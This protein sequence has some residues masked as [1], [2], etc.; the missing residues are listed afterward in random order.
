MSPRQIRTTHVYPPIPVRSMDWI[1]TFHDCDADGPVGRGASEAEAIADLL[2]E[3]NFQGS[4]T[5][6]SERGAA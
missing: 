5:L 1:A 2:D 6:N 4:V 3:S